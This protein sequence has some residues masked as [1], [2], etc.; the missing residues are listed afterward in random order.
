MTL[1]IVYNVHYNVTHRE[2]QW[3]SSTENLHSEIEP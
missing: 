1:A 2:E 3:C